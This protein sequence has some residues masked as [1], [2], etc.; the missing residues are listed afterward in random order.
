VQNVNLIKFV[1]NFTKQRFVQ[2][3]IDQSHQDVKDVGQTHI[4][5]KQ[6]KVKPVFNVCDLDGYVKIEFVKNATKTRAYANVA[7]HVEKSCLF[8]CNSTQN[9]LYVLSVRKNR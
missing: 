7:D 9:V 6:P 4:F 2:T 8:T 1:L 3:E 5:L